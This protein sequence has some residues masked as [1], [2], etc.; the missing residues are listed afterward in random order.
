MQIGPDFFTSLPASASTVL[1]LQACK[2]DITLL[3]CFD[4]GLILA[5]ADLEL[6][7]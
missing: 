7:L 5:Q 2:Q 4:G 6:T 3:A 1:R